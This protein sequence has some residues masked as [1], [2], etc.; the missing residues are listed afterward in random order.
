MEQL[1]LF[2][3]NLSALQENLNPCVE[4]LKTAE[5][6]D[7]N[8]SGVEIEQLTAASGAMS[9]SIEY[10]GKSLLLHSLYN[11]EEEAKKYCDKLDYSK[12]SLI[13]VFGIGA[14]HHIFELYRRISKDS[15]II[16]IE[17]HLKILI[18]TLSNRDFTELIDSGKV[19]F[20]TGKI[21][22]IK[23]QLIFYLAHNMHYISS[24]VQIY[25]LP[26]LDRIDSENNFELVQF[27]RNYIRTN[28][29]SFGNLIEDTVLGLN[30]T[31]I[32]IEHLMQST[33]IERLAQYYEGKPAVIVSAGPS[34]EKNMHLLK[35]VQGKA[36]ILACDAS[37]K[38]LLDIGVKP[39]A[40]LSLERIQATYDYFYKD[41]QYPED[42]VLIGA[43]LL[44]PNIFDEYKGKKLVIQKPEE[45]SQW[46]NSYTE[47]SMFDLGMSVATL[48]YAVARNLNC[49]PII[50]IGQDLAYTDGKRHS[51]ETEYQ[52]DEDA[53][54]A[55]IMIEGIDGEMLPSL[56]VF[57]LFRDWFERVVLMYPETELIDATEGGALIK[58]CTYMTF[59]EAI[60][61]YCT[62]KI[63]CVLNDVVEPRVKTEDEK[64]DI[65]QKIIDDLHERIE[66]FK[67]LKRMSRKHMRTIKE[68]DSKNDVLNCSEKKL[69]SILQKLNYGN[70]V[71][72]KIQQSENEV[73]TYFGQLIAQAVIN[74]KKIG[75]LLEGSNVKRNM[76]IQFAL[77]RYINEVCDYLIETYNGFIGTMEQKKQMKL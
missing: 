31:L 24:N 26:N 69:T 10:C 8:N 33:P 77:M 28:V 54:P 6:K 22:D 61:K 29:Y 50:L 35:E 9:M 42:I 27:V 38:A 48:S 66:L 36:L 41:K 19:V 74:V 75:N 12:D 58:G 70:K 47:N 21:E 14:G 15:R 72:S 23:K 45:F 76:E 4:I 46:I 17:H 34:L 5:N 32:N 18:N 53:S 2:E 3:K 49:N 16:V 13:L 65:I 60:D 43:Q 64:L 39:D 37:V 52:Q 11:P 55:Q 67:D 25:C 62:E 71:I 57:R 44:W 73:K 59:R 56:E 40:M 63:A 51:K 7:K 1:N 68:L 30:N 20:A